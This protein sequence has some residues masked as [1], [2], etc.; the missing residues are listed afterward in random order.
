MTQSST[1][2]SIRDPA[3]EVIPADVSEIAKLGPIKCTLTKEQVERLHPGSFFDPIWAINF[4]FLEYSVSTNVMHCFYCRLFAPHNVYATG[5]DAAQ[6]WTPMHFRVHQKTKV[7]KKSASQFRLLM[8]DLA[9]RGKP[10]DPRKR[11][12]AKERIPEDISEIAKLGPIKCFLTK[13]QIEKRHGKTFFDPDWPIEFPFLEYSMSKN[14]M[15]CFYCRLIAADN[16]FAIGREADRLC[17][18]S[19]FRLHE[20][21][22]VHKKSVTQ[23]SLVMGERFNREKSATSAV[24]YTS[25][26]GASTEIIPNGSVQEDSPFGLSPQEKRPPSK[27]QRL[28]SGQN[29]NILAERIP[30]SRSRNISDNRQRV[31]TDIR[32][33]K[34]VRQRPIHNLF[35]SAVPIIQNSRNRTFRPEV[36]N[37]RLKEAYEEIRQI[38]AADER[39][40]HAQDNSKTGKTLKEQETDGIELNQANVAQRNRLDDLRHEFKTVMEERDNLNANLQELLGLAVCSGP[41]KLPNIEEEVSQD[42]YSDLPSDPDNLFYPD[43]EFLCCRQDTEEVQDIVQPEDELEVYFP[44]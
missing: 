37:K 5:R 20:K 12:P 26:G 10:V 42:V 44:S 16:V 23:F 14:K 18:P 41:S 43:P 6:Y 27:R 32:P 30:P 29:K 8:K 17:L 2:L 21:S 33:V 25:V 34:I 22:L 19:N 24:D 7:H 9:N 4:P 35:D 11:D 1:F 28:T 36:E 39:E 38:L 15:Y 13:D 40:R 31:Q 3:T